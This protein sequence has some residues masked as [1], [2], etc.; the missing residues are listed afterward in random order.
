MKKA[1]PAILVLLALALGG[2]ASTSGPISHRQFN[3]HWQTAHGRETIQLELNADHTAI[4]T[5]NS[6]TRLGSWEIEEKNIAIL[7]DK[8]FYF[9]SKDGRYLI[10]YK[11]RDKSDKHPEPLIK[12]D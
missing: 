5:E 7:F 1:L 9:G 6:Q 12:I 10:L 11:Y 2:C 8:T 4:L 3:G